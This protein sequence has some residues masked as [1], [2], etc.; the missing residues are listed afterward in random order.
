[1]PQRAATVSTNAQHNTVKLA[2]EQFQLIV[3]EPTG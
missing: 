3:A 2:F 1:M